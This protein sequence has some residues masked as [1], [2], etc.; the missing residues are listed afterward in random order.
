MSLHVQNKEWEAYYVVQYSS[1]PQM[2]TLHSPLFLKDVSL[3]LDCLC[4]SVD[5]VGMEQELNEAHPGCWVPERS[6]E[7]FVYDAV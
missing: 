7:E 4:Y 2:G 3:C 6:A 1:L 5:P